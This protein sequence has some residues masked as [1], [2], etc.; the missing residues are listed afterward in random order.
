M[1]VWTAHLRQGAAP[2]LVREGFSWGAL[3]LGP[4][5]LAARGAW[6][7]AAVDFAAGLLIVVLL[8]GAVGSALLAALAV[9]QGLFGHDLVRWSLDLRGY[10]LAHVLAA[11]DDEAAL[12]RLLH[13][14]PDLAARFVPPGEL[15]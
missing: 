5:W 3:L 13:R 6:V 4:V 10:V 2:E 8:P 14:R 15:P 7:P 9:A 12:A 1:R 11:P